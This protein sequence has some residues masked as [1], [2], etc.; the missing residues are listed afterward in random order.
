MRMVQR[1]QLKEGAHVLF[2]PTV[3]ETATAIYQGSIKEPCLHTQ[4]THHASKN[5]QAA[6]PRNH[7]G[8]ERLHS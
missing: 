2:V 5:K 1:E 3:S 6:V 4:E 8:W 7:H